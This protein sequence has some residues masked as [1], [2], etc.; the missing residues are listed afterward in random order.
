LGHRARRFG[1][2]RGKAGR[3]AAGSRLKGEGGSA[4]LRGREGGAAELGHGTPAQE[5][6]KGNSLFIY[7]PIFPPN[8]I[9]SAFF[10]ET[11][12]VSQGRDAWFGMMHTQR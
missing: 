8:L 12:Q 3:A 5:G 7:F 2:R 6:G 10:M 9:L 11:K 1:P 4:G